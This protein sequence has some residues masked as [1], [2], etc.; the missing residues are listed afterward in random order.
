[1]VAMP[2]N[3]VYIYIHILELCVFMVAL[4]I[5][6]VFIYIFIRMVDRHIHITELGFFG[7]NDGEYDIYACILLSYVFLR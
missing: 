1:M 5:T 4:P 6:M 3:M 7:I 2:V